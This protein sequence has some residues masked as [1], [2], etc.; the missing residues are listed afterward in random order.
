MRGTLA[1]RLDCNLHWP[2]CQVQVDKDIASKPFNRTLLLADLI[3][4]RRIRSNADGALVRTYCD[5]IVSALASATMVVVVI[6][7]HELS[8]RIYAY[9]M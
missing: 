3:S 7:L 8:R 9:T 6:E 2:S 1:L 4:G 5:I